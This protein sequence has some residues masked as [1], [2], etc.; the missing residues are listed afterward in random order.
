MQ[1]YRAVACP[2]C[3]KANTTKIDTGVFELVDVHL[4]K[5]P[6]SL[7]EEHRFDR[8]YFCKH[9]QQP[10]YVTLERKGKELAEIS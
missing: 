2:H 3:G 1:T 6:G 8:E 4:D 10:Y 5:A 9:C 7:M